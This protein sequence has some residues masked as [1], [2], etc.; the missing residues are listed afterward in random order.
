MGDELSVS[1]N[2]P[3]FVCDVKRRQIEWTLVRPESL[4][5]YLKHGTLGLIAPLEHFYSEIWNFLLS[6]KVVSL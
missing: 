5:C 2:E 3:E 1:H 4:N 6:A